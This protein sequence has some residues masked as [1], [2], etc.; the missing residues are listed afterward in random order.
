[1]S[2]FELLLTK[3]LTKSPTTISSRSNIVTARHPC[4]PSGHGSPGHEDHFLRRE[5][6]FPHPTSACINRSTTLGAKA[7]SLRRGRR[8][9]YVPCVCLSNGLAGMVVTESTGE[10]DCGIPSFNVG[11]LFGVGF[12]NGDFEVL[13]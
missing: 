3:S 2:S 13:Q 12:C 8:P 1:V 5:N 7:A 9:S 10:I 4:S 11:E 6:R